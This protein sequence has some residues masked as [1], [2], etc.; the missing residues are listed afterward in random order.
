M[1]RL[2]VIIPVYNEQESIRE[3]YQELNG[4]LKGLSFGYEVIVINDG[5]RD[6][7]YQ[8]MKEIAQ[9]DNDFKVINFRKNLG[10]TA[11][12]SAGIDMSQGEVIIPMDADLQNDPTDIPRLLDKVEEGFDVVSGWRKDRHDKLF[13]RKIPSWTAN[14]L[15]SF[16]T[17]VKLHDYGCTIKAYKREVIKD[18]RFYGEMH[19]FIPAY[20]AWYGARVAEIVVNHR[21]RKYGKTKYTI[22]KTLRVIL[23]LLTVKFLTDYS[24][25]PMHFFGKIGYWSFLLGSLSGIIALFLKFFRGVSLVTTPLPLL[26]ALLVIISIQFVLMGLLAEILTRTYHES[27]KKPIYLIKEKINF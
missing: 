21:S 25:K 7:G 27:Q 9:A 23:D 10:Q 16:I 12:M 15:I 8:I 2:S 4:V 13:T 17:K 11:A 5:S 18:V 3:L 20:T 1:I 22:A 19:R 26:T 14:Y 6:N 24:T